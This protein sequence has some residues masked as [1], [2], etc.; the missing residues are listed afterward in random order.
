MLQTRH[1]FPIIKP[2]FKL[3]SAGT[4]VFMKNKLLL[5]L[6]S[7]LAIM[8]A[9]A[10]ASPLN[11]ESEACWQKGAQAA[12]VS[13]DYVPGNIYMKFERLDGDGKT[14]EQNESWLE[15]LPGDKETKLL[16]VLENGKDVTGEALEKE[17]S[18]KDR[19][20]GKGKKT[21]GEHS[22]NLA[23]EEI[24]PLLSNSKK[25]IAHSYLGTEGVNGIECLVFGFRKEY[26]RKKGTKSASE[27]HEG[28]IWLD[29]TSGMPV[30][31]SYIPHPLPSLV[32]QME[33]QTTYISAGDRFFVKSHHLNLKAG[34]LFFKKRFRINFVL[35]AFRKADRENQDN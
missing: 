33:M 23:V 15:L 3:L 17:R 24:V 32:K 18:R 10:F 9:M 21:D 7:A 2:E 20:K 31:S 28:K 11:D 6:T 34:F 1:E 12:L 16:K 29:A 25:P 27:Y 19:N 14:K 35:D 4:G 26:L 22:I 30:K 5:S 8:S 13:K